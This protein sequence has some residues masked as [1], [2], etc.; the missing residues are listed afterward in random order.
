MM[1]TL[2]LRGNTMHTRFDHIAA[3]RLRVATAVA[4]AA[5]FAGA[6]HA[7]T[8]GTISLGGG[9]LYLPGTISNAQILTQGGTLAGDGVVE[10]PVSLD[11]NGTLAPG[12]IATAGVISAD[13]LLWQPDGVVHHRLGAN[14]GDSDHTDLSGALTRS[15]TGAYHFDFSDAAVP[16]VPGASYTLMTFASQSG[17]SASDF[18]Y[19]YAGANDDL[20]GEFQLNATSL[21]FHVI[22]TPVELQSFD[23]D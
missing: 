1:R 17:F 4:I 22:S 20:V 8:L 13:S 12:A 3:K 21:V 19:S 18:D 23:V 11:A 16:P 6:A 2:F 7:G 10:G 14:D 5:T 15:G 9:T